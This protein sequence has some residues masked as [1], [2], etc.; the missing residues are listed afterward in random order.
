MTADVS[1]KL[2]L[3][4]A[5]YFSSL[6]AGKDPGP[7]DPFLAGL[8]EE[9]IR[10]QAGLEVV[11][12]PPPPAHMNG[13][14]K[15]SAH[16]RGGP[17]SDARDRILRMINSV[18]TGLKPSELADRLGLP[19]QNV[20][21]HVAKMQRQGVLAKTRD[22]RYYLPAKRVQAHLSKG[23]KAAKGIKKIPPPTGPAAE[24]ADA[25]IRAAGIGQKGHKIVNILSVL[26]ALREN[27]GV[28]VPMEISKATGLP[29]PSFNGKVH[30]SLARLIK[31]GLAKKVDT[32]KYQAA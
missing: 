3:H 5:A 18:P 32:G 16:G 9:A 15:G 31:A 14:N 26:L 6:Q 27:G 8:I 20:Q 22:A 23:R 30:T 4:A 29:N 1:E 19:G 12:V 13:H 24:K 2:I 28:M 10:D 11:A 17:K 21:F 25:E 7:V